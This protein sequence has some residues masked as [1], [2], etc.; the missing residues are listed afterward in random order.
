MNIQNQKLL[1]LLKNT[2]FTIKK[3]NTNLKAKLSKGYLKLYII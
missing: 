3:G 2:E 1:K